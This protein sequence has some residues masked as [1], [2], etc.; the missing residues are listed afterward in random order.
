MNTQQQKWAII[1]CGQ[2]PSERNCRMKLVCPAEDVDEIV[3]LACYH[4]LKSHGHKDKQ[5]LRDDIRQ[6]VEY[7]YCQKDCC[8]SR[9]PKCKPVRE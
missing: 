3:D 2:Y 8:V 1:D 4:A 9:H 6:L 7:R 5:Q